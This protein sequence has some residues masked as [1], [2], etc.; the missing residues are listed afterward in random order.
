MFLPAFLIGRGGAAR[1]C[2]QRA[3][4][5][6]TQFLFLLLPQLLLAE[7]NPAGSVS[8]A[9]R[10]FGGGIL[11]GLVLALLL[12]VLARI[13]VKHGEREAG[14]WKEL[15]DHREYERNLAQQELVRRLEEERELAKEKMQFESQ[16]SDYEKYASLAQLALG[17]AHE[18]N[19]PLLGI[20]SHLELE[21]R[22]ATDERREEIE[23]CIEGA[24]RISSAVRGLLDY[25]RPGPL[26]LSKVNLQRLTDE[27]LKF[28]EHQPMFRQIE[29]QNCIPAD[30][31]NISADANQLSQILMNLLLNAAQAT[32]PGGKITILADKVKFA[33]V[34][35][36][37]VRDTGCGI[38]ADILPHVF[39][40]FFTTKRGQGNWPGLE[41]HA[42]LC[43]QSRRRHPGG[44]HSGSRDYGAR[45]AAHS[46]G[47]QNGTA[48][49]GGDRLAMA[50]SI[51]IVD[52]EAL[53]LR[54][55]GRALETE[56]YE[57]LLAASGEDALKTIAEEKP[58]LALLDVVLPGINGIEVLRQAKKTFPGDHR[59]DDE[60]L[61]HGGSRGGS[62]EAGRL[63]L[64]DQAVSHCGHGQHDS[65]RRLRCWRCGCG[66]TTRSRPPK[67][68][69]DFG[70]V[71]TQSP[72]MREVLEMA[73]RAAESDHTTILIQGESGTGKE[74]LAKAI[75]YNS[76]RAQAPI[77]RR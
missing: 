31:P 67:D 51:L 18:I 63:R 14:K 1:R 72:V 43:A 74:V 21:W 55:I 75:H 34:I 73:R 45:D 46:P 10:G 59:G 48:Q 36:L 2:V 4:H 61:S 47:G 24:K 32:P 28:L 15:A 41:H 53:T 11:L 13:R 9:S 77:D 49:R 60:R 23:Q 8:G 12:G 20:L 35:E 33:E 40:P 70:R 68:R 64:P 30:L 5:W 19:N 3:S 29:L 22:D 56:G 66:C 25:A 71:V 58:D 39:E 62:H 42:K 57:V 6:R 76:S 38:P 52:D 37:R 50:H 54:T 16:L 7:S 69:Y 44:K 27:T 26:T 17:A 65:A